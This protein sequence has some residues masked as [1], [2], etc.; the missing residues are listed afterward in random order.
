VIEADVIPRLML[1]HRLDADGGDEP[2]WSARGSR[3]AAP[4][5]TIPGRLTSKEVSNLVELALYDAVDAGLRYVQSLRAK[6]HTD[7]ALF[8]QL[9]A[10]AARQL[11]DLW[12]SD[13]VTFL[14]VTTAVSRLQRLLFELCRTSD[15]IDADAPRVLLSVTPGEQHTMGMHMVACG[16][17]RTG[18]QVQCLVP[19]SVADIEC[20]VRGNSFDLIGFSLGSESQLDRLAAVIESVRAAARQSSVTIVVG[21]AVV[22]NGAH[23]AA[24]S[25][26]DR[27]V[28]DVTE[29][30]A[31]IVEMRV[32]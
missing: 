1:L 17:R 14:Q 5:P 6:G 32:N 21:G 27:V 18:A 28:R 23:I 10:P 8:T 4:V 12:V 7:E 15:P 13:D 22:A 26:A 29:V 25:G 30:I 9:L 31:M 2:R 24:R 19:S 20:A 3:T 16:L 11:G